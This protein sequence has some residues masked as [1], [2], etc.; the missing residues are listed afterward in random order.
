VTKRFFGETLPPGTVGPRQVPHMPA[1][2]AAQPPIQVNR[3]VRNDKHPNAEYE[4]AKNEALNQAAIW[5]T[6]DYCS[7]IGHVTGDSHLAPLAADM[8]WWRFAFRSGP[9]AHAA[10]CSAVLYPNGD[11]T[12]DVN[13]SVL[14]NLHTSETEAAVV[15]SQTFNYGP[16]PVGGS[17]STSGWC[18]TKT[19][20]Q[21]ID[22]TP[23]TDY[24]GLIRMQGRAKIGSFTM[25][26]LASLTENFDGYLPQNISAQNPILDKYRQNQSEMIQTM[27]PEYGPKVFNWTVAPG[28]SYA[29]GQSPSPFTYKTTTSATERNI[30]DYTLFGGGSTAVSVNTPGWQPDMQ[31][32]NRKS[33]PAGVGCRMKAFG[34]VSAGTGGSVILKDSTGASVAALTNVF[35]TTPGWHSVTFDLPATDAKYDVHFAEPGGVNTFHLWA[36]SIY[37]HD[38]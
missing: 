14:L 30:L 37:E 17:S 34:Y 6:K 9:F 10:L 2:R 24:Y 1:S 4:S 7:F 11:I 22:I 19:L 27:Q 29:T 28:T 8:D 32:K 18:Y 33:Q 36:V 13:Q 21:Y 12:T 15:A 16:N 26:E 3:W 35:T 31:L 5:R 25:F 38:A 20:E 23:S